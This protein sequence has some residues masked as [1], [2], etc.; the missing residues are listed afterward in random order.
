M[1]AQR[2][3]IWFWLWRS[4]VSY[5]S[6]TDTFRP[7]SSL[8]CVCGGGGQVPCTVGPLA[9]TPASARYVQHQHLSFPVLKTTLPNVPSGTRKKQRSPLIE[10][11]VLLQSHCFTVKWHFITFKDC[12]NTVD[13]FIENISSLKRDQT[14]SASFISNIFVI[15]KIHLKLFK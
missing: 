11:T 1:N 2:Q 10:N 5:S 7:I 9:A 3:N 15:S 14:F 6:T 4:K 13:T 8:T 12:H